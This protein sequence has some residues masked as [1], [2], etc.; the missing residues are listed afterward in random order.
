MWDA[1]MEKRPLLSLESLSHRGAC[2]REGMTFQYR[3]IQVKIRGSWKLWGMEWEHS[4]SPWSQG[5]LPEGIIDWHL[6]DQEELGQEKENSR[7]KPK[8][9]GWKRVSR[10]KAWRQRDHNLSWFYNLLMVW[11]GQPLACFEPQ[12]PFCKTWIIIFISWH[13]WKVNEI[14]YVKHSHY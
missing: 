4:L 11:L 12:I 8:P 9:D 6:K 14:I 10:I 3:V 13:Y 1:K 7:E 2:R 5:K